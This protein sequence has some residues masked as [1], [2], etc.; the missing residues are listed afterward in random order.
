M[1][2][3]LM[4][5]DLLFVAVTVGQAERAEGGGAGALARRH[6]GADVRR[7]GRRVGRHVWVDCVSSLVS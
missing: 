2:D 1:T 7:G 4:K 5:P 3:I 6:D